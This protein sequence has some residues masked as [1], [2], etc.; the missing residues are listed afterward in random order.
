MLDGLEKRKFK[1]LKVPLEVT[2]EII[3]VQE[4]TKGLS[5][6]HIKS[7]NISMGGICLETKSIEVDGVDLMSGHPFARKN[8]L[9]ISIGLIPQEHPF[10]AIGEVLWY[11]ISHDIPE[12]IYRVGVI[13]IEIK[14][15]GKD[16]LARF[17]KLHGI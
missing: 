1:R 11:D 4:V 5:T 2:V 10:E 8:R 7:R 9:R 17:L 16:H 12:F 3:S 14:N 15:N 6:L 13:F